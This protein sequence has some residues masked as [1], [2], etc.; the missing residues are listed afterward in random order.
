MPAQRSL[1]ATPPEL[2]GVKHR[3]ID[4]KRDVTIHVAD[5][6]PADG[7]PV[8]MVHG[9]P[10]N[11]WMW[12][13][14]ISPLAA[15]GYR[16]L[17]PDMRGAGWS[18]APRDRY[19]KTD[20]AEDL[21]AVL[22]HLGVGPVT[23]VAHDWGGPVSVIMLLRHREKVL[24]FFGLNTLGPWLPPPVALVRHSWR[25]AYQ[26]PLVIPLVGPSIIGDPKARYPRMLARWVNA[27][28]VPPEFDLYISRLG[29]PGHAVAASRWYRSGLTRE[30][31]RWLHGEYG[32][33]RIDVPVRFLHGT[34][35]P[36][37]TPVLVDA[38]AEHAPD[39]DVEMVDGV[40]HSVVE[41]RSEL[42]LARLRSF[43]S[44]TG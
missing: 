43:L 25:F 33:A 11:W 27:G 10:Q 28:R 8:M 1:A 29:Q 44:T 41:E 31:F 34:L 40:G 42:V 38:F 22:D 36:A 15:D 26:I 35:D 2:E 16:V 23:L 9:F 37:L 6:G 19:L 24:G 21:A 30:A 39:F 13:K 32:N 3:Y 7:P 17:C 5:A 12:H 20:M 18:A 4:V 14:L